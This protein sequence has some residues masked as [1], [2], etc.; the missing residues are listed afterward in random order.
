MAS[1]Q[2]AGLEHVFLSNS[3]YLGIKCADNVALDIDVALLFFAVQTLPLFMFGE[4]KGGISRL[5]F[6]AFRRRG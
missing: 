6:G 5:P 2:L 3:A 1:L 4:S